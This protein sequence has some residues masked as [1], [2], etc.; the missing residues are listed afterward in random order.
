MEK[1]DKEGI[2]PGR[3]GSGT[4]EGSG[5]MEGNSKCF[6]FAGMCGRAA[7]LVPYGGTADG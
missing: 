1:R 2:V 6:L 4:G 5:G 7:R 3:G